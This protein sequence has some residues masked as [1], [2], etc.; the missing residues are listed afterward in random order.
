MIS[1]MLHALGWFL[2]FVIELISH[3]EKKNTPRLSSLC[4]DF[5]FYLYS[6]TGKDDVPDIVL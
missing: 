3:M 1:K 4:T 6:T 2:G 5:A